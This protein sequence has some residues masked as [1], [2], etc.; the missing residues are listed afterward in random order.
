MK[1][2]LIFSLSYYPHNVSGAEAAIKE[3]TDRTHDI[4]FHMVTL[5]YNSYLPK[6]EKIGN[7]LIHRIGLTTQNPSFKDLGK[8]P[9]DLNKPLYQLLTPLKAWRLHKKY[10]YD[11]LWSM[12]AHST[13][14][15]TTIFNIFYPQ[16]KY[17][18]TLQEGDPIAKIEKTMR[19]LWPLFTKAF[20][21]ATVVQTISAYLADWAKKR[22]VKPKN[23]V[24]IYNGANP[25]DFKND[26]P[27]EELNRLKIK[28]NKQTND[29]YLVNT[30]RLVAQKGHDSVIRALAKL[31][32]NI[33]FLLVGD[34][35]EEDNLKKLSQ[36]LG[37]TSRVIFVGAV[38]RTEV[39]KYR[40]ISDI[41][42]GPSRSEGL[43]NAFLSAM[44]SHLPVIA[45]RSGGL[46]EFIFDQKTAWVV[47]KDSPQQIAEAVR[48]ILKNPSKVKTIT[49]SAHQMV[50]EKY[51]W[52]N[53]A[54]QMKEKI[55]KKILN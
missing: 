1:K 26:T 12:M 36:E 4:E 23:I 19:P 47:D 41:F 22:G 52:D 33:K 46:S 17:A 48:D 6:T 15:P 32:P 37:L 11:A 31:E 38:D 18:L 35:P 51:N 5:R 27:A 49:D 20:S 28:L 10:K 24:L 39:T 42:V 7:I 53:I 9:L 21:Q 34:G 2:I 8:L 25:Q 3:I 14:V 45:T 16:I 50:C 30:A 43:G 29:I 40:K 55:F 13:G 54:T 44:A